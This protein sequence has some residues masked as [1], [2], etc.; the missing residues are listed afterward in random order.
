MA[1]PNT[2]V[3]PYQAATDSVLTVA[4]DGIETT[5]SANIDDSVTTIP[6]TS[7]TGIL[8][9]CLL[10]IED[11]TVLVGSIAGNNLTNC[12]RGF[13]GTSAAAHLDTTPVYGYVMSYHHNQMAAEIASVESVMFSQNLSGLNTVENLAAYSE[14]FENVAWNKIGGVTID[15]LNASAPNGTS[16]ARRILEGN[17]TVQHALAASF[18]G[19]TNG[20]A[21]VLS[22][23]AKK[24]DLDWLYIGQNTAGE[25]ARRAWFNINTGVVGTVGS[26]AKAAIVPMGNG[27]FRC[28]LE[29]TQTTE[30]TKTFD[31]G[32]SNANNTL[33]YTGANAQRTLVWGAQVRKGNL[34]APQT[35]ITTSGVS[36]SVV[37]GG[38]VLDE[39]GLS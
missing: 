28:L 19:V 31:I 24:V 18:S 34:Q 10:A 17:G 11:E 36:M 12:V 21:I 25:T 8:T 5:L 30:L 35:Y 7:T 20:D 39:G 26:S 14:S 4:S 1:N 16:T 23:Y 27:W 29:T 13:A 15:Q 9:P 6:V 33:T 32:I 2:S 3:F 22:V 37:N 38:I